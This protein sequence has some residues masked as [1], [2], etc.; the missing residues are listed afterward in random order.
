MKKETTDNLLRILALVFIVGITVLIYHYRSSISKLQALGLP[1]VFLISLLSNATLIFPVPGVVITT[2]MA[3][4]FSPLGVALAAGT[5]AAL[6]ELTGY[7]AG[8]S[9]QTVIENNP[10]YEKVVT[11]MKK[12]GGWTILVL[13]FIPNPTFDVAGIVSGAL[14]MPLPLF[15]VACTAGKILKN[16]LFAYT[17]A[18]VFNWLEVMIH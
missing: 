3:G 1:G 7:L 10:T 15:L 14:K 5:G 13:A 6:G 11:W 8:Y 18:G 16:L 4:I 2:T 12:Y 9:G 17:G